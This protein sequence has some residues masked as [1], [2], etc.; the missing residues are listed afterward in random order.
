[1]KN[2]QYLIDSIRGKTENSSHLNDLSKKIL[3]Y[4]NIID[5]I[6][7]IILGSSHAQ[8]G[9]RA[10]KNE[11]NLGLSFQD[12]YYSYK[13]YEKFN[14]PSLKN[15]VLFYSVFSPGNQTIKTRFADVSS[16]YKVVCGIDYQD[17]KEVKKQKLKRSES[18]LKNQYKKFIKNFVFESNYRGN[19]NTYIT[20]FKPPYASERAE[21]HYK[22]NQRNN[23]QTKYVGMINN[24]VKQSGANLLVVIPPVTKA[25]KNFLPESKELFKEL[26]CLAE[27]SDINILNLYSEDLFEDC[28]FVDWDHL[29]IEGANK[30]TK[31]IN[32]NLN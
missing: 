26:F 17:E 24:L 1:M 6:E 5:K 2:L 31:I 16:I 23:N 13:L 15:I 14:N 10:T 30:L 11:F 22:N 19:E 4:N 18:Y 8:L 28:E 21:K 9:Y 20:C 3:S 12:L 25:Y 29:N 7:T 32:K 27:N